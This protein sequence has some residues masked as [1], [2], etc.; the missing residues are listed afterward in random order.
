MSLGDLLQAAAVS[1]PYW[2][3][4]AVSLLAL[5]VFGCVMFAVAVW[6]E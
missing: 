5:V 1:M 2:R 4:G 3:S 6:D